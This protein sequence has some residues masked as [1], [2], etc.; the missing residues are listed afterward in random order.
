MNQINVF[1]TKPTMGLVGFVP[2]YA[3]QRILTI[4]ADN[5]RESEAEAYFY[6]FVTFVVNL[7]FA[8][9]DLIQSWHSRRSY[10]RARGQVSKPH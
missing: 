4:L 3:L 5:S 6:A 10:E 9:V 2:V 7:S 8:Q 1:V